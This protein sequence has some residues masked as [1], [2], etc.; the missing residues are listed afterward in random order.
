MISL[1]DSVSPLGT[2]LVLPRSHSEPAVQHA[3]IA[4]SALHGDLDRRV[5]PLAREELSNRLHRFAISQF[6]RALSKLNERR[7][8]Q[9]PQFRNVVLT[10]C[11]LF[12][13]Y[14]WLRGNGE[15]ALM[16]LSQGFAIILEAPNFL[17]DQSLLSAMIRLQN[18]SMFF[19]FWPQFIWPEK[20]EDSEDNDYG[21][22]TLQDAQNHLDRVVSDVCYVPR[23]AYRLDLEKHLPH[24]HPEL[25]ARQQVAIGKLNQF[26]K[27]LHQTEARYRS[28]G[29]RS[30]GNSVY[31]RDQRD[32]RALALIRLHYTSW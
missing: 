14:E 6:G 20:P 19:G 31:W 7:H 3:V 13:T 10:C 4:L 12:V 30:L 17:I 28:K 15:T 26:V 24:L 27:K 1:I 22:L 18:Q 29:L 11:L 5:A 23:A 16:H 32:Q 9:D 21:F 25:A 2:G 8:S